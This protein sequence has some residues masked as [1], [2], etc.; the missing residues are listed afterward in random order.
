MRE[1]S[2][3]SAFIHHQDF[4]LLNRRFY[5]A[6]VHVDQILMRPVCTYRTRC[7]MMAL[8]ATIT[9]PLACVYY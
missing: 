6:H 5:W 8:V 4:L 2:P 7:V 3:G 9:D 1:S